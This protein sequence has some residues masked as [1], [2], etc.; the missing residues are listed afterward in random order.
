[1]DNIY[2]SLCDEFYLEM[3][4]NTEL[5]LPS[6]RDTILTFFER[7]QRQYPQMADFCRK[8]DGEYYLQQDRDSDQCRWVCLEGYRL[9]SGVV[10]PQKFEDA[11]SQHR[12]ILDLM[13]YMLGVNHLDIDLL[14]VSFG[15][16]FE[17]LGNHDE[18][19][20]EALGIGSAFGAMADMLGARC[21]DFSPSIVMALS[22]DNRTQARISVESKTSV[23]DPEKKPKTDEAI[24][25]CLT[26]RQYPAVSGKF[27]VLES[28][29]N[30]CRIAE[31][32]MAERILPDFVRPLSNVIAQ[33]RLT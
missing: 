5:E 21:I 20:A 4:V 11:Y 27:D 16:D 2:G 7:I 18:V 22:D 31:E 25:L 6:Q 24:S 15:M 23:Y 1:M 12:L 17:Y 10:S 28:F 30:Q 3:Y 29:V 9:S 33:K 19:I 13:P 14:D 26:V 8:E 32:L